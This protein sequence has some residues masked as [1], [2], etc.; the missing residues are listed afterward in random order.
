[1]TNLEKYL[2]LE[3]ILS[4]VEEMELHVLY[5]AIYNEMDLLYYQLT[6]EECDALDNRRGCDFGTE[7]LPEV[8]PPEAEVDGGFSAKEKK[9]MEDLVA[10]SEEYGLYESLGGVNY[11]LE[12]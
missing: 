9:A 4:E 8:K 11:K 1:M 3:R 6:E 7:R 12:K 10:I 2:R 5:D